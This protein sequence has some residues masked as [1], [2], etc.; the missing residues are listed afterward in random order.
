MT[1]QTRSQTL[2]IEW[3]QICQRN[4]ANISKQWRWFERTNYLEI[5]TP[6]WARKDRL[7]IFF[8]NQKRLFAEGK[9]VWAHIVQAN[10]LLFSPGRDGC[11]ALV[12]YAAIDR[13]DLDPAILSAIASKVFD[14]KGT[15]PTDP[16]LLKVADCLTDECSRPFGLFLPSSFALNIPCEITTIY[17]DRKHLP[18][19]YLSKGIFPMI[20]SDRD[21]KIATILPSLYWPPAT[22]DWWI[23]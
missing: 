12:V 22:I 20:V 6:G 16:N 19:G 9:L 8:K 1:S 5:E 17:V 2:D 21:P 3:L 14:L 11:P 23:E 18:N 7:Q 10:T 15:Q 13:P 4:F